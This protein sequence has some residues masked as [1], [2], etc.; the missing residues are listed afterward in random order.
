MLLLF[1]P[2]PQLQQFIDTIMLVHYQLDQTKPKPTN[3]LPPQPEH[4]L[5]F[6]PYD[7]V[8]RSHPVNQSVVELPRSIVVGPKLSRVDLTMGYNTLVIIVRFHPGGLHRFL[9]VPMGEML[10]LSIDASLL[11]GSEIENIIQQINEAADYKQ[12]IQVLKCFLLKKTKTIK[13]S[14]PV[15]E[16]LIRLL[17]HKKPVIIDQ[18]AR[19]ACV[20]IRQLERQFK[21]RIGLPPKVFSRLVRFSKAW[22]MRENDPSVS[23]TAI[24]HACDYS[25]Q[26]HM[27]RDFKEFTGVTPGILQTELERSP[28]RLQIISFD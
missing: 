22:V 5:Y 24:A 17:Q 23:W 1:K 21:E 13:S 25:D 15:D 19:D 16:V 3:P 12:M 18:L 27:I 9:R 28:L 11:F 7:K 8:I 14:L 6:Y 26:M 4:C 10:D 2:D 20:S